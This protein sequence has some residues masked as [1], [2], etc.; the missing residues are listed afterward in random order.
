MK[1][2]DYPK[3]F[4]ERTLELVNTMYAD[5]Q[6]NKK[7]EVT[8]LMNCLLGLI[9]PI[10]ENKQI[11]KLFNKNIDDEFADKIPKTVWYLDNNRDRKNHETLQRENK[12]KP[13]FIV[14]SSD[15]EIK[16]KGDLIVNTEYIKQQFFSKLR[17]AIAHQNVMARNEDNKWV[18]VRMWNETKSI[19]VDFEIE[20]TIDE[21]RDFASYIAGIYVKAN[22]T[23]E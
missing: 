4:V 8:F 10:V 21:L 16:S 7:L 18:G 13:Y 6:N 11:M 12:D 17:N 20:F 19:I 14:Q 23:T 3:E 9:V 2:I 5:I 15:F 22:K 1:I